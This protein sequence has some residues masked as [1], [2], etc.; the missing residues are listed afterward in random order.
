MGSGGS[1]SAAAQSTNH[2]GTVAGVVGWGPWD[3]LT[4]L[5][6][7]GNF[8]WQCGSVPLDLT[9][10]GVINSDGYVDLTSGVLDPAM[11]I[12]GGY[13]HFYPGVAWGNPPAA[14]P[15]HPAMR[16]TAFFVAKGIFFGQDSGTCPNL[17]AIGGGR[18]RVPTSIVAAI[19]NIVDDRQVNPIA[20]LPSSCSMSA[21]PRCL[22]LSC[23][24]RAG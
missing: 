23:M 1:S 4:A 14:L 21:A 24:P 3:W 16:D 10:E 19:D 22:R 9:A 17:Q 15:G 12:S 7:N 13:L 20:C 6:S 8:V 5:I 18:P 11:F 2:Y